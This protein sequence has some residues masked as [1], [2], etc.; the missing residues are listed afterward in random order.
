MNEGMKEMFYITLMMRLVPFGLSFVPASAPRLY[1]CM[2]AIGC[3][4]KI[5][6]AANPKE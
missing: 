5:P 6:L 1:V 2:L 4:Y 3:A